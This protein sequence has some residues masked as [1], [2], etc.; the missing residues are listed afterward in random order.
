MTRS[1]HAS[2][3]RLALSRRLSRPPPAGLAPGLN[4]SLWSAYV[5]DP[6]GWHR[7]DPGA[8]AIAPVQAQFGQVISGDT[9]GSSIYLDRIHCQFG[10][11][12]AQGAFGLADSWSVVLE[13]TPV[14]TS[15]PSANRVQIA[16]PDT[17]DL[18]QQGALDRI[19]IVLTSTLSPQV[20]SLLVQASSAVPSPTYPVVAGYSV[21]EV[22]GVLPA[23]VVFEQARIEVQSPSRYSWLMSV[24]SGP[25][26]E[27]DGQCAVVF[28]RSFETIDE[29]GYRAEFCQT[30]DAGDTMWANGRVDTNIAKVRWPYDPNAD[31]PR[32]KEGG[33]I[34]DASFG[35]WYKIQKIEVN[36]ERV[37]AA[38]IPT[39]AGAFV[40]TIMSLSDPV[41]ISTGFVFNDY[42][43]D[44]TI[45]GTIDSQAVLL[46]GVIH[47]FTP[48]LPQ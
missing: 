4:N 35:Y 23:G 37:N 27:F 12:A 10:A 40:R 22:N 6:L 20:V 25:R 42:L 5:V 46:P 29:Q 3:R 15:I 36:E 19:R 8:G 45:N 21:I 16:F 47:V 13:S 2:T 24:H 44:G 11:A 31:A 17:V 30:E 18:T 43:V 34:F 1:R 38:D 9:S 41:K 39:A 28:N 33:Y 14:V 32:I 26:G 7:N 48:D